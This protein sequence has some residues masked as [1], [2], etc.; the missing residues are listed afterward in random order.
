MSAQAAVIIPARYDSRRL[1]G[2]AVLPRAL[3]VTGKYI[4]QHVYDRAAEARLADLVI[5]ATDDRRIADAVREFGGDVCM[6]RRDHRSGT[7]RITEVA[8]QL[9]HPII[10][11]VQ[12]DEPEILPRQVDQAVELL[13][14]DPDAVMSTLA[15]PVRS[16]EEWRDPNV[17][18]VVLD[19]QGRALYFSRSAIPFYRD[20]DG[21]LPDAPT[22][23][24]HHLGIYGYRR[25]FLLGYGALPRSALEESEKLEQLRALEAGYSIKV[26]ITRHRPIGIDTPRDLEAWLARHR[27]EEGGHG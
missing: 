1:R 23:P 20:H 18:K 21:A 8:A 13:L 27:A 15:T 3:R 5:V 22:L 2:K 16:C 25:D 17:V 6:T 7:D 24:L 19:N 12:G 10:V 14:E 11:N 4:I 9:A 26:G